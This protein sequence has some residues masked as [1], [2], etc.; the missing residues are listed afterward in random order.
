MA[1]LTPA[2]ER[3]LATAVREARCAR[4]H[5]DCKCGLYRKA[6]GDYE[7]SP[8][9]CESEATWSGQ[10]DRLLGQIVRLDKVF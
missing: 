1:T 6:D 8:Y 3:Q 2:L 4:H 9:C 10:V 5:R 7:G